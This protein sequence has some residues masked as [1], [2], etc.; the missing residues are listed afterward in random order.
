MESAYLKN[1]KVN[2][3]GASEQK[4]NNGTFCNINLFSAF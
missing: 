2:F 4:K 3:E 1:W